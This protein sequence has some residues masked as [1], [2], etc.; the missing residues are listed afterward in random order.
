MT[1]VIIISYILTFILYWKF[2][3]TCK[4]HKQNTNEN[5]LPS[6]LWYVFFYFGLFS[7]ILSPISLIMILFKSYQSV[8]KYSENLLAENQHIKTEVPISFSQ[9]TTKVDSDTGC[10]KLED[11]NKCECE[12]TREDLVTFEQT[13]DIIK[14]YF[15]YDGEQKFYVYSTNNSYDY[16]NVGDCLMVISNYSYIKD[17][18]KE[19]NIV[20][21]DTGYYENISSCIE[22]LHKGDLLFYIYK[23]AESLQKAKFPSDFELGK[24]CFTKTSY[25]RAKLHGGNEN[26]FFIGC[27]FIGIE[28]TNRKH[29]LNIYFDSKQLQF[30]KNYSLHFLLE[31]E[32]ILTFNNFTKPIKNR[33]NFRSHEINFATSTNLTIEHVNQLATKKL[34]SWQLI[35]NE[36]SILYELKYPALDNHLTDLRR[37][38]L[39]D[40]FIK[41]ITLYNEIKCDELEELEDLEENKLKQEPCYVYLM[42]DTANG[43]HKIGISNKPKYR[44]HTLQSDKPTIELCCA[45]KFPSRKIAE[46]FESSLHK[47]YADKR[48]RGEWFD[49]NDSEVIEIQNT[50][51]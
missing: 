26:G 27:I 19:Y 37:G 9:N 14:C 39:K 45:K 8:A 30:S 17:F 51:K 2:Y 29:K 1:I 38:I 49:L 11:L 44:E 33:L 22:L 41:Y 4:K 18:K 5:I 46:A 28:Y 34:I 48:R 3:S 21:Y 31:D 24:D 36:G 40:Y 10:D 6:A 35:N 12:I 25:I 15:N 13:E 16:V 42:K 23:S 50:F 43:S 7:I 20:A 32:S 47:V